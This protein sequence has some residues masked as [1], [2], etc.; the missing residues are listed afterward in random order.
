[1]CLATIPNKHSGATFRAMYSTAVK[2]SDIGSLRSQHLHGIKFFFTKF[3][4]LVLVLLLGC[5]DNERAPQIE[6]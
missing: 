2:Y 6:I 5:V 1:M 3:M 4:S